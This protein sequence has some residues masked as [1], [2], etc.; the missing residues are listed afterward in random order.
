M[1]QN[2][3]SIRESNIVAD[4]C[5]TAFVLGTL[6]FFVLGPYF[7]CTGALFSVYWG[8]CI[9]LCWDI[10]FPVLGP[11][12][13]C[14]GVFVFSLHWGLM[15]FNSG[16]LFSLYWGF[17]VWYRFMKKVKKFWKFPKVPKSLI[18]S[19]TKGLGGVYCIWLQIVKQN[20]SENY[21][22]QNP[23]IKFVGL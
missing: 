7:P 5:A 23:K 18:V 16:A 20:V 6:Y 2:E 17:Y 13:L 11:Y 3:S 9:S 22:F 1:Y 14:T 15:R 10:I 12:F 4:F 21:M 19:K 8:L